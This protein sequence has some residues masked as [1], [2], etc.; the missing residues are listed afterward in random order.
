VHEQKQ[1]EQ[2]EDARR[3]P[4]D[5]APQQAVELLGDLGLGEL[6]LL[7]DQNR[8]PVRYLE[9]ELADAHVIR[10][11]GAVAGGLRLLLSRLG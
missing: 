11:L 6:D 5:R 7:A 10:R 8:S 9:D 1:G 2:G 3:Q 4:G